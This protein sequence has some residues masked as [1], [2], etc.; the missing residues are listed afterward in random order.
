MI[1]NVTNFTLY[2]IENEIDRYK[3]TVVSESGD[4]VEVTEQY[5]VVACQDDRG[6]PGFAV[7][8]R[9]RPAERAEPR[10]PDED[11]ADT[12]LASDCHCYDGGRK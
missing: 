10:K 7:F 6:R 3:V 9:E 12:V 11:P 5:E 2:Q 8:F 1:T 4:L